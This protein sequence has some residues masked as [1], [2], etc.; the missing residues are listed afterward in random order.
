MLY[1]L[2][3]DSIPRRYQMA[4]KYSGGYMK[5][6]YGEGE[7]AEEYQMCCNRKSCGQRPKITLKHPGGKYVKRDHPGCRNQAG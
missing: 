5:F 3:R 2:N 1:I 7:D 6:V 4:E